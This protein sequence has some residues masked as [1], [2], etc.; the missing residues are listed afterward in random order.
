MMGCSY[1]AQ[2]QEYRS[3]LEEVLV[4]LR[5]RWIKCKVFWIDSRNY[6]GSFL[7]LIVSYSFF[8]SSALTNLPTQNRILIATR[9]LHLVSLNEPLWVHLSDHRS[10][11]LDLACSARFALLHLGATMSPIVILPQKPQMPPNS[12]KHVQS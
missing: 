7:S 11:Y 6:P 9:L 8:L 2:A 5:N 12:A 1:T 10:S 3:T 4:I